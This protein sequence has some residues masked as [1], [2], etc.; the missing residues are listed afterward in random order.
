M[1]SYRGYV[2]DLDGTVYLG[3]HLIPGAKD[4]IDAFKSRGAHVRYIT[5][6]PT[7]TT[8]EYA[9]KLTALGIPTAQEEVFNTVKSSVSWL[10]SKEPA[11]KVYPL[12]EEVLSGALREAGMEVTENPDE[13]DVVL[14]SYDRTLTYNKLKIAFDALWRSPSARLMATNPDRYCPLPEGRGEPDAGAIV[15]ALEV[16]TGRRCE[17]HFGKPNT[18]LL[19]EAVSCLDIPAKDVIFVGDR[20]ETDIKMAVTA[21]IDSGLVL[22]GDASR[23]DLHGIPAESHPTHI[24]KS[25]TELIPT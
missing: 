6:N 24:L 8:G 23:E 4:A 16:A 17:R 5:N 2:F 19:D 3:D 14:V 25:L 18:S 21:G 11:S 20:L 13:I 1:R 22:T 9:D 10:V 7:K 12:G 15:A